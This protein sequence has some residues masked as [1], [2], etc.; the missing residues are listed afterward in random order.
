MHIGFGF[1]D[2]HLFLAVLCAVFEHRGTFFRY[3]QI[4]WEH[5]KDWKKLPRKTPQVFPQSI[6]IIESGSTSH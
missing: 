2:P 6:H 1:Q 4:R 3:S 5:T